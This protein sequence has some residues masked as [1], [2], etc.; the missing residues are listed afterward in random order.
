M[1]IIIG[2]D[3]EKQ[4]VTMVLFYEELL[5]DHLQGFGSRLRGL[6]RCLSL[7]ALSEIL[8]PRLKPVLTFQRTTNVDIQKCL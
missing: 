6:V 5:K 8:A 7:D 3:H 4:L 1:K 2:I